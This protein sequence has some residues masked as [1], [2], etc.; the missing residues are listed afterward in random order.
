MRRAIHG[1]DGK[2]P[3]LGTGH[4]H[5]V[6]ELGDV[7]GLLPENLVDDLRGT[8]LL[9]VIFQQQATD[10]ILDDLV[11]P[12]ALVVPEHHARG[13]GLKVQ[14]IQFA[15]DLAMVPLLRFFQAVQIVL[16]FF[17]VCPGGTVNALEHFIVRITAP[18]GARQLG[19]FKG[20]DLAG[21]GH[22]GAAAK[23]SKIPL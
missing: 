17:F 23:I 2:I 11:D 20:L 7:P 13:L 6:R 3:L 14:K 18:I 10:V 1:L 5:L 12:P 8:H 19:Q 21:A 9:V 22:M 4:E 16:Q 15:G